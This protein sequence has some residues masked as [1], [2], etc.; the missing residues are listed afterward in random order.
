MK[1][2]VHLCSPCWLLLAPLVMLSA[3]LLAQFAL[4]WDPCTICV[5][6]R[7]ALC[8]CIVTS[9]IYLVLSRH[10][11]RVSSLFAIATFL[12]A[13]SAVYL[14]SKVLFIEMKLIDLFM[15]SPFPFYSNTLPLQDW[16]PYVFASAGVCG[17]NAFK[18]I[19][20]PFSAW[21]LG[22]ILWYFGFS[23]FILIKR[24]LPHRFTLNG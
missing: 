8:A 19:G 1:R 24:L 2:L 22:G 14:S 15:C 23:G 16:L 3:A 20:V 4:G 18:L 5:E 6:I 11:P 10:A 21:S 13:G 9:T 17:E 7:A 12:L